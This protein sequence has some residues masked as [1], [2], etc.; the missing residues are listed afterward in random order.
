V[1]FSATA[2]LVLLVITST[3]VFGTEI[4]SIWWEHLGET[5]RAQIEGGEYYTWAHM[6]SFFI[7]ARLLGLST[8]IAYALQ[9]AAGLTALV[10][11]VLVW[12]RRDV[13]L[14]VKAGV[15][16]A[17]TMCA[18]QY[19]HVYDLLPLVFII[20]WRVQTLGT[21]PWAPWEKLVLALALVS[22]LFHTTLVNLAN[23]PLVPLALL[24]L[25]IIEARLALSTPRREVTPA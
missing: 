2:T 20:G 16:M 17:G 22:P 4:W 14:Y 15:L 12:R 18:V 11:T 21:H 23:A 3:L 25:T 10:L 1:I 5:N 13:P 8:T 6:P 24:A 9:I 7:S 19:T